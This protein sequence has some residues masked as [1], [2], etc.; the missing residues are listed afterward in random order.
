MNADRGA[1][2]SILI[3]DDD[4]AN[5]EVLSNFLEMAGYEVLIARDGESAIFRAQYDPPDL[6]CLDV[7]M[8]GID[9]FETCRRLKSQPLTADIPVIFMTALSE[10]VDQVKGLS[11]G[12]VDY[13]PKPFYEEV[14]LSRIQLH[15]KLRSLARELSEQNEQLEQLV[16][17]R[18][19]QLNQTIDRL[20]ATQT[21]LL[22]RERQL[23]YEAFHDTLTGLPNRLWLMNHL[24]SLLT[25]GDRYNEFGF[26][27]LFLDLDR[28][29]VINDSLGHL[30]GDALLGHV[31]QRLANILDDTSSIARLGGDEFVVLIEGCCNQDTVLQAVRRIQAQF[32]Q[33]FRLANNYE[34]FTNTSIGIVLSTGE[35]NTCEAVLRDADVAMYQ[36]KQNGRGRY[37]IF[38][39]QM[40]NRARVRLDLENELR[41]AVGNGSFAELTAGRE[42]GLYYQPLVCLKTGQVKGFEALLR[43]HHPQRG[44]ISP[45]QFV[46]ISEEIGLIHTLGGWVFREACQQL[47]TWYQQFPH[48]RDLTMNVNLSTIQLMQPQLIELIQE[49]LDE[50][51]LPNEC[52]K[53]EITE[54]C[55]LETNKNVFA[56]LR[57]I[58]DL[59][60]LLCIDDFGTGYSSLSRLHEFP[61]RTLKIDKS[62]V[63]RLQN[64]DNGNEIVKTIVTLAHSL[65]MDTVAE[66]IETSIQLELVRAMGCEFA[67]GYLFARPLPADEAVNFL[68]TPDVFY[69]QVNLDTDCKDFV[70]PPPSTR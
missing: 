70:Q 30:T 1:S 29:K 16:A 45:A 20:Q 64:G 9:G 48:Q 23:E 68:V 8:P 57:K 11:L 63:R 26:A 31:A 12:A 49:T 22:L 42:F 59:G 10:T 17:Q 40:R 53:L 21:Q 65:D 62:F 43:W 3:V 33:A 18:T 37:A 52:I 4:P 14:V 58:E 13:I 32:S 47:A 66:G 35:Y 7:M 60:L 36:A 24:E 28:F 27:L 15:L 50:V 2:Q 41:R 61:V 34:V 6:I 67:Q 46:P 38:N 44:I 51:R 69:P 56:I 25:K 55:L 19:T 39:P 54:S 5:L